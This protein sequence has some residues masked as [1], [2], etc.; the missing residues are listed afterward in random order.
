MTTI[1]NNGRLRYLVDTFNDDKNW[2]NIVLNS[3]GIRKGRMDTFNPKIV[4]NIDYDGNKE[5]ITALYGSYYITEKVS[6]FLYFMLQFETEANIVLRFH[7]EIIIYKCNTVDY[8]TIINVD[9]MYD[10]FVKHYETIR[11]QRLKENKRR[12]KQ[13]KKCDDWFLIFFIT[14]WLILIPWAIYLGYKKYHD[15]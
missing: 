8:G 14:M 15:I 12:E 7:D 6:R 1:N 4:K 9:I 13:N 5:L 10:Y 11:N 3:E 2:K